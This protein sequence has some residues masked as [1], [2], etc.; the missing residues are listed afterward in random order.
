MTPATST[1]LP[2]SP[3]EASTM[4]ADFSRSLSWST[5]LRKRR[6]V[7]AFELRGHDLDALRCP[8]RRRQDR[9]P[10]RWRACPS[11]SAAAFRARAPARGLPAR[12]CATSSRRAAH[13]ARHLRSRSSVCVDV[14]QR[15]LAGHRLDAAHAG[16]HAGFGDDLE[17][18][19]VA[20]AAAHA[21]R[22]TAR[23]RN[24]RR[25][26]TRTASPYFSPNSAM[27]PAATASS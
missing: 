13:Q 15:A 6:G 17:Q 21:C 1:T 24:R 12:A 8:R 22:R 11:A 5:A 18:A 20:G 2:P 19:D 27:A 16:G 23:W 7:G 10:A 25:C 4:T 9:C 14:V 26:S 3:T